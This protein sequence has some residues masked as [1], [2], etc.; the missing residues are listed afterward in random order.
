M[1]LLI[2]LL[3]CFLIGLWGFL[4]VSLGGG[5]ERKA[6]PVTAEKPRLV[7]VIVVDQMRQDYLDRFSDLYVGGLARLSRGGAVFTDAHQD[8]AFTFTPPGHAVI[9]TGTYPSRNG[10]V[11]SYWWDETLG[12]MIHAGEDPSAP[13]V[14]HPGSVGASPRHLLRTTIGD[15]LKERVPGAKVFS[16]AGKYYPAVL[17]GGRDADGAYWYRSG[18]LVTSVY[19]KRAYPDWVTRFNQSGRKDAYFDA[20]WKRLAPLAVYQRSGED[21]FAAEYDGIHTTFPHEFDHTES[22]PSTKYY[23]QLAFTPFL[24]DLALNFAREMVVQEDLGNDKDPDLL[25]IGASAAD[26]VGHLY[27]PYSQEIQDYYLRLDRMLERFIQFL[28][29]R[30]GSSRYR[31]VL[32]SDHGMLPMKEELHRRGFD[33]GRVSKKQLG[34]AYEEALN[35]A[36]R[37][38]GITAPIKIESVGYEL[39]IR[40]PD[41]L[42]ED[43]VRHD[44]RILMAQRLR[45]MD[46]IK[47]AYTWDE[48]GS[49]STPPRPLLDAYRRSFHPDRS[50]DIVIRL[51]QFHHFE[52]PRF[53]GFAMHGSPYP[54]DTH[55]PLVLFGPEVIAGRYGGRVRTVDIAP[56]IAMLLGIKPPDDLDGRVLIEALRLERQ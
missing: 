54:Y 1:R 16:V 22:K 42:L 17:V 29:E 45:E 18:D 34:D 37:E 7:I 50:P 5:Q 26:I 9:A 39:L 12:R 19:Y 53:P 51:S 43:T 48:L 38:L 40:C 4:S 27:G 20:G 21:K 47:G 24:D 46:F 56:T 11:S 3:I 14:G 52:E 6:S 41:G 35:F 13:I 28:N 8:H 44:L 15:W 30:V 36:L 10:V 33:A 25:F 32:T 55:V 49:P 23:R 31:I 2:R